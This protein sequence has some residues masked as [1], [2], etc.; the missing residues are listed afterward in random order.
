MAKYFRSSFYYP[1]D[2]DI[3]DFLSATKASSDVMLAFL[4]K[5]GVY[6]GSAVSRAHL[7][8]YLSL[9]YLSWP[10]AEELVDSVN[11][12]DLDESTAVA[13]YKW[14]G[15][16]ERV[17]EALDRVIERRRD[18]DREHYVIDRQDEEIAVT[19]TY[20]DVETGKTRLLQQRERQL[21]FTIERL[22][23]GFRIRHDAIPR[24]VAIIETLIGEV[25]Q[26][27]EGDEKEEIEGTMI[28]LSNI[29][30][31]KARVSFFKKMMDTVSGINL[32]EVT[33]VRVERIAE[34]LID[35]SEI[36]DEEAQE[37]VQRVIIYGSRLWQTPEFQRL[38]DKHFFVSH[39]TWRSELATP[40]REH[41]DI[42]AG[43]QEAD[44]CKAFHYKILGIY[45]RDDDG[46]LAETRARVTGTRQRQ[47]SE[48]VEAAA[49]SALAEVLAEQQQEQVESTDEV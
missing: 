49:E 18:R 5:R 30:T 27:Q 20:I 25:S 1:D 45:K 4:R 39:A 10:S 21:E 28:D 23:S 14:A 8:D 2:K 19:V 36:T 11:V 26:P 6:A 44:E 43:F 29:T 48:A 33:H 47:L 24:A 32:R 31:A 7:C 34:N 35:D 15:D 17:A 13:S 46:N 41:I 22:E 16:F 37:T 3:Y 40:E 38:V 42:S 12:R 9:L